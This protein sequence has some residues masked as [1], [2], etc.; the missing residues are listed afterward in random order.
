MTAWQRMSLII[1]LL[2]LFSLIPLTH[3]SNSAVEDL[4][5]L[6]PVPSDIEVL[7]VIP[8]PGLD[9]A[10]TVFVNGTSTEF[11]SSYHT[12]VGPDSDNYI[13]LNWTHVANTTLDFRETTS[14]E[15]PDCND[16]IYFTQSFEW[17]YE[18][19]PADAVLHF[20]YRID[21]T[22]DFATADG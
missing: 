20:E 4:N 15:L 1:C 7:E 13:E 11:N 6:A 14:Y 12:D 18:E 10:P 2:F 17:P 16:F 5:G 8:D 9:T 19:R 22:E 21:R 3:P